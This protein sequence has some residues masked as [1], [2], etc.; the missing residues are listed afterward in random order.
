MNIV[1]TTPIEACTDCLIFVANGEM[2]E[3]RENLAQDI[4]R[5][6]PHVATDETCDFFKA[7]RGTLRNDIVFDGEDLGFSWRE[8]ECC[9]SRLGGDR[10]RLNVLTVR[11]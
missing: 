7:A 1:D 11:L 5:E 10:H 6:W 4:E 3:G 9:G 2:P 8:C